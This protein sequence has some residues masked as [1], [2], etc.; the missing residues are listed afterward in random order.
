MLAWET[1]YISYLYLNKF[2]KEKIGKVRDRLFNL[3]LTF[4]RVENYNKAIR[5][6]VKREELYHEKN[7]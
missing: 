3:S 4:L 1:S 6:I 5:N 7:Y 2:L